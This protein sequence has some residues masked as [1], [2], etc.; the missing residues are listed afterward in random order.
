MN[1]AQI[2]MFLLDGEW[3][4]VSEFYGYLLGQMDPA[5]AVRCFLRHYVNRQELTKMIEQGAKEKMIDHIWGMVNAHVVEVEK[6]GDITNWLVR[7]K[8]ERLE[9][10]R[11]GGVGEKNSKG[12]LFN[13]IYKAWEKGQI[14]ISVYLPEPKLSPIEEIVPSPETEVV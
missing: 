14:E 10:L 4:R 5:L 13:A 1:R 7:I 3:H 9:Y 2:T 11:G 12:K 6:D 8:P